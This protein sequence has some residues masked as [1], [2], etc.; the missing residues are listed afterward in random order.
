SIAIAAVALALT[1]LSIVPLDPIKAFVQGAQRWVS[2]FLG[3]LFT[4]LQRPM[5][6]AAM[7]SKVRSDIDWLVEQGASSVAVVAH[8]QGGAVAYLALRGERRPEVRLLYT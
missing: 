2:G 5:D 4:L 7:T 8:S 1:I 3:D 6:A